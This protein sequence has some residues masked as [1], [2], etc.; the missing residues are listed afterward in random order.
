MIKQAL[1][2]TLVVVGGGLLEARQGRAE[3]IQ[4]RLGGEGGQSWKDLAGLKV[5][6]DDASVPGAIQSLGLK[7][8][9][10][11]LPLLRPWHRWKHPQDLRYRPGH[12]RIW[13]GIDYLR[14]RGEPLDFV[15]GDPTTF[16]AGRD[17]GP[18]SHEFYT[19]DLGTPVPVE[20]FVFYPPEGE[21]V[22]TGEPF[23]PNFA[24]E[25]F[26]LSAS[27]DEA[28]VAREEGDAYRPL[29]ILLAKGELNIYPVVE[30]KFPLQYLRFL[31]IRFFPDKGPDLFSHYALAE[32]EVYGRGVVPRA[33]WE[34]QVVDLEQVVN[35]GQVVFGVS[36]WRWED[37]QLVP[38]PE[39]PA[40]VKVQVR[41]GLDDT[42]IAY[43]TYNDLGQPVEV[44]ASEYEQLKPRV[45]PWDPPAVGWQ[46]LI[47]DDE[48]NWSFWSPPLRQSGQWPRVSRGQYI[49]VRVEL[50]TQ[51]L[52]EFARVESLAVEVSPLLAERVVGEVAVVGELRPEEGLVRVR[53][54]ELSEFV[55]ELGAEF[56]GSAQPGF[57]AVRVLL[58]SAG[59]FLGLEMGEP[60][61]AVVPDSTV[62]EEQGFVVYLPERVSPEKA[63]RVRIRLETAVYGVAGE[64]GAEVFARVGDTLPQRVEAGDVSAEVGTNQLRVVALTASLGSVLEQ[65][66][67]V[68]PVFTPQGDGVNEGVRIRYTL[69]RVLRGSQ[70]EVEVY[71]LEGKRVWKQQLGNQGAGRHAVEWDGRDEGG[72][73]VGPGVYLVR[74]QVHTD[75]GRVMRV[76]PVAVAY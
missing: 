25:K 68:P 60:L 70:V 29:D 12:P 58:P 45:W 63:Q 52:W 67:V 72:R 15:D 27:N 28:R 43:H 16:T 10:N 41:T 17:F 4:W 6:V 13:R 39:A 33:V 59:R 11:L 55:Y 3:V 20:R 69:F 56:S 7:P 34:S 61:V 18:A 22:L 38:A 54:G 26:E 75:K 24:F 37:R 30:I 50:A 9:E 1:L 14:P 48:K 73:L 64:L 8:D 21:Y 51:G 19:I 65:V 57:D 53:G 71:A 47:L 32:L 35:L 5:M 44:S 31:R 74:V 62:E 66:E 36:K 76:R 49:Q 40:G 42:P 46:G 23:R 2:T